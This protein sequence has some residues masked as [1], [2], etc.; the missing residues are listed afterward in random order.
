MFLPRLP[1]VGA[2]NRLLA[3]RSSFGRG[4][5]SALAMAYLTHAIVLLGVMLWVRRHGPP[6]LTAMA[7]PGVMH[8]TPLYGSPKG[9][10]ETPADV[11]TPPARP[12]EAPKAAVRATPAPTVPKPQPTRVE[13]PKPK[14]RAKRPIAK[15]P[16][17]AT[18]QRPRPGG[19][20]SKEHGDDVGLTPS[21]GARG[22]PL[23]RLD[24]TS[25]GGFRHL[26]FTNKWYVKKVQENV[27]RNW[28]NPFFGRE[29]PAGELGV[30]VLFRIQRDGRVTDVTLQRTSGNALYDRS[31]LR[32]V[33]NARLP[34]L[35][36]DFPGREV[37]VQYRFSLGRETLRQSQGNR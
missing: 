22:S 30:L 15:K 13:Q 5:Q 16:K 31:G 2:L 9:D 11:V 26:M 14:Q 23:G 3:V 18:R 17:A 19:P 4:Q 36:A 1:S 35:P 21:R 27:Y 12:K 33:K 7:V 10:S 6:M 37:Q 34:P 25:G 32:A 24:G 8:V 29:P 28:A 20:A